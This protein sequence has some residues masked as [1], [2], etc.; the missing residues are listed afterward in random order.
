MQS[1]VLTVVFYVAD[2]CFLAGR[3]YLSARGN[4]FMSGR[5]RKNETE[6]E[7]RGVRGVNYGTEVENEP[8]IQV[9][10]LSLGSP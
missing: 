8:S 5:S 4:G 2:M 1:L 6:G 7:L 10:R 3:N 9:A